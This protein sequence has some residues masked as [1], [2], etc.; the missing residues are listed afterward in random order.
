[1]LTIKNKTKINNKVINMRTEVNARPISS[2]QF[3]P[4]Q[5]N[6]LSVITPLALGFHSFC[7]PPEPSY[8]HMSSPCCIIRIIF[9]HPLLHYRHQYTC[10]LSPESC[11][12]YLSPFFHRI[13]NKSNVDNNSVHL[14]IIPQSTQIVFHFCD[15]TECFLVKF[16]NLLHIPLSVRDILAA[17]KYVSTGSK[18]L[19]DVVTI[20]LSNFFY[21]H[22]SVQPL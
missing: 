8:C 20:L 21:Y 7:S 15:S 5:S 17:F 14:L 4:S 10:D 18:V 3:P 22:L 16:G 19:E 1:M 9:C 6:F 12:P 13:S 2:A 11:L